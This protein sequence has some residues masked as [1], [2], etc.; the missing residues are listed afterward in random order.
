MKLIHITLVNNVQYVFI[1]N[2]LKIVLEV[3][4]VQNDEVS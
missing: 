4:F 2:A 3:Y 1:Q